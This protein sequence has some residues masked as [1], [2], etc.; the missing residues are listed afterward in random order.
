VLG[1]LFTQMLLVAAAAAAA[2][3]VQTRAMQLI[4]PALSRKSSFSK[5]NVSSDT[6]SSDHD[7]VLMSVSHICGRRTGKGM[8]N[9]FGFIQY[10][11]QWEGLQLATT[12]VVPACWLKLKL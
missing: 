1:H 4:V 11:G 2:H 5:A 3:D 6:G 9:T 7:L 12:V 8:D 10:C